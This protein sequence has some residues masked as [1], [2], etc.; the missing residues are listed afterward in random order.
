M[1][2]NSLKNTFEYFPVT[3]KYNYDLSFPNGAAWK[4]IEKSDILWYC[5]FS[6]KWICYNCFSL[7]LNPFG[8]ERAEAPLPVKKQTQELWLSVSSPGCQTTATAVPISPSES[9][10]I[11]LLLMAG[12][13]VFSSVFWQPRFLF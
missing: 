12:Q 7:S 6:W 1:W 10:K 5:K 11:C 4:L 13:A 3:R 9:R 2:Y 8:C